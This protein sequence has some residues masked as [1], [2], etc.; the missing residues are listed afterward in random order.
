[1]RSPLVVF[2]ANA[3][4]VPLPQIGKQIFDGYADA[5]GSSD[6]EIDDRGCAYF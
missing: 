6:G 5:G 1:L 3:K 2:Y 4:V